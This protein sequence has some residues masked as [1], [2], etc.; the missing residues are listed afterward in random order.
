[1]SKAFEKKCNEVADKVGVSVDFIT[2]DA[3]PVRRV[4][5][6]DGT[7]HINKGRRRA[8]FSVGQDDPKLANERMREILRLME[9]KF[10][11]ELVF[12]DEEDDDVCPHC[13]R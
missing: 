9:V 10:D 6:D 1:M 5:E 12:V 7:L 2:D 8:M 3:T 11:P 13:G 4:S